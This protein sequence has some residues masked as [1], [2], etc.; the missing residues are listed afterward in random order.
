VRNGIAASSVTAARA[1]APAAGRPFRRQRIRQF[2][3]K[4]PAACST[5]L[6]GWVRSYVRDAAQRELLFDLDT[7]RHRLFERHGRSAEH[8]LLAKA[9]ANLLRMWAED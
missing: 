3:R 9:A 4:G 7:A 1:A 5:R 2:P 8:D 6:V